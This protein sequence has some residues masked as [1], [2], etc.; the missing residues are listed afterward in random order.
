MTLRRK[1]L[2][3]TVNLI[4]PCVGIS[5]LTVL[6][7]YLPSDSGEKVN[8]TQPMIP[9]KQN[10]LISF[11]FNIVLIMLYLLDSLTTLGY[12]LHIYSLV[13]DCVLF[14]A[15]RNYPTHVFGSTVVGKI[16]SIYNDFGHSIYMCNRW[17]VKCT[18]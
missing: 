17:R 10:N 18:F 12:T 5:F 8:I 4:I 1:T 13:T 3:Y 14:A 6:V 2:F 7:F 15:C 9:Q 11:D 16:S